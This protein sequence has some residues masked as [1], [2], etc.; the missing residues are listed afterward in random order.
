MKMLNQLIIKT[1]PLIPKGIIHQVAKRYI[2]GDE[3]SDAV[4]VTQE[5][6]KLG[7]KTTID[8]LGEFVTTK[9][10]ALHE[11]EMVSKVLDAINEFSLD[12]YLSIKPTSLGLGIDENFGYENISYIVQKANDL[13]IFVRLDM[14]NS[15]YTSSTLDLYR[16]L[17]AEGLSNVGI[18]IQAYM[19]RSEDDIKSLIHLKPSIRLCKGIYKESPTIAYQEREE[20]R[21]NYKKL[22]R[23]IIDNGMYVGIATHDEPLIED[24]E[25]LIKQKSISKSEYEFQMLLGVRE[26]KR[27]ELL[28]KGHN[29]RIYV[30]FGKDWYG[31]ST[32]RLKENPDIAGYIFKAIFFKN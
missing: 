18:V 14:E 19:R 32:R 8:V 26:E 29:V 3:L 21:D 7:G 2:A 23:L 20:I 9:E 28:R 30:P 24:A 11:K 17:R 27:N 15:P 12:S 13:N 16:K 25:N 31:Y 1:M 5:F 22:L 10:R 6:Q 4:R